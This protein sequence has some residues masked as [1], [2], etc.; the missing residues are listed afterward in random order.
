IARVAAGELPEP[1][2]LG[3]WQPDKKQKQTPRRTDDRRQTTDD[4][5]PEK[6]QSPASRRTDAHPEI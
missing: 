1:R 4:G 5:Q 6:Q 2:A 3:L